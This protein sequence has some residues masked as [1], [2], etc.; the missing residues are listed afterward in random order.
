MSY[1]LNFLWPYED[2]SL[3]EAAYEVANGRTFAYRKMWAG[4]FLQRAAQQYVQ[5]TADTWRKF[6]NFVGCVAG[7]LRRR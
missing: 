7:S 6:L 4:I 1:K 2:G 5:W 3:A